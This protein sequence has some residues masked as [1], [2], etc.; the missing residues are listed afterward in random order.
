MI[1]K[2]L[3]SGDWGK[4]PPLPKFIPSSR[5]ICKLRRVEMCVPTSIADGHGAPLCR[6]LANM[7]T[8]SDAALVKSVLIAA[9][10]SLH[11]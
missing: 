9:Y 10:D 11:L 5:T 1:I 6:F 8:L 3:I 2:S 7:I 4:D